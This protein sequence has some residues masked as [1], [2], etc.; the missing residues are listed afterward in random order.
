MAGIF[1]TMGLDTSRFVG[2]LNLARGAMGA[3]SGSMKGAVTVG[4]SLASIAAGLAATSP[5]RERPPPP[6]PPF[7]GANWRRSLRAS[8]WP[9]GPWWGM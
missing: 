8:K 7:G 1:Y 9:S 4:M 2:G 3:F 6:S 5:R